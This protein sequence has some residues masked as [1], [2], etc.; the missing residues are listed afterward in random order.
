MTRPPRRPVRHSLPPGQRYCEWYALCTNLA[1]GTT[2][3]PILGDVPICERCAAKHE[4]P[5]TR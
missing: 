3:H 5:I 2:P 1:V 4:L